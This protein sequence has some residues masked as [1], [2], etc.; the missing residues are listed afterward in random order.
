MNGWVWA[1]NF[2]AGSGDDGGRS[3]SFPTTETEEML[4]MDA[5]G[6]TSYDNV[7]VWILDPGF[8]EASSAVLISQPAH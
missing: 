8:Y 2:G 1:A 4:Q 7:V 6:L 5:L 3:F